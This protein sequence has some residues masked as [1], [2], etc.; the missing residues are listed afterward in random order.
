MC[1]RTTTRTSALVKRALD[2]RV[3][4]VMRARGA[5]HTDLVLATGLSYR[6]LLRASRPTT[7]PPLAVGVRIARALGE[8]LERLFVLRD[9]DGGA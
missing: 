4:V 6:V 7:D 1:R 8:P 5:T 3:R 9:A 2:N